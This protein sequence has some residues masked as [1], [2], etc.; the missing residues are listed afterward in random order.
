MNF[1]LLTLL[2]V[3]W[4]SSIAISWKLKKSYHN[5]H[6]FLLAGRKVGY[7]IFIA[8][9]SSI[10]ITN[11]NFLGQPSL[12]LDIGFMGSYLSF[13]I[14][15]I[16]VVSIFFLKRLWVMSKRFGYITPAEMYRDY[17]RNDQIHYIAILTSV[18]FIIPFAGLQIYLAFTAAHVL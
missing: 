18:L 3:F 2:S 5:A 17:F 12:N 10:F 6:E 8:A 14:I 15:I 16:S 1:W 11:I 4:L 7:F 13:S 9:I